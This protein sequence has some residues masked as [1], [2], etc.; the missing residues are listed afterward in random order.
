MPITPLSMNN[1]MC[2]KLANLKRYDDV[3]IFWMKDLHSA[4]SKVVR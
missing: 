2:V 3:G 1:G 4:K